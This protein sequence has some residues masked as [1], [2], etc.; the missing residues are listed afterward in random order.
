ML[1][2]CDR[3]LSTTVQG[4]VLANPAANVSDLLEG[5]GLLRLG[6]VRLL[7][8]GLGA[9]AILF[10]GLLRNGLLGR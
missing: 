4:I 2:R 5:G 8:L 10:R 7:I 1:G 9:L 3:G 6:K